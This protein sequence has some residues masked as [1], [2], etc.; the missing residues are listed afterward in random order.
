[1]SEVS[2][3][4]VLVRPRQISVIKYSELR[5]L[6]MAS[7]RRVLAYGGWSAQDRDDA[8]AEA[9]ASNHHM[10]GDPQCSLEDAKRALEATIR[11]FRK[12]EGAARRGHNHFRPEIFELKVDSHFAHAAPDE[13][14]AKHHRSRE[15]VRLCR[16]LLSDAAKLIAVKP[17]VLLAAVTQMEPALVDE[18]LVRVALEAS[19]GKNGIVR[20][21]AS[22]RQLLPP[23]LN[24]L[25]L[26]M[27]SKPRCKQFPDEIRKLA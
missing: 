26:A 4:N 10:F 17:V 25:A 2:S 14:V 24:D 15:A 7:A 6:A 3:G 13:V 23:L 27:E 9:I 11:R 21:A 20:S 1:M 8:A 22:F 16:A 18:R 5:E 12:V 19:G